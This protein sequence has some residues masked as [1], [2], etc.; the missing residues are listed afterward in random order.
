MKFIRSV[1]GECTTLHGS[2]HSYWFFFV[3]DY[4]T[5]AVSMEMVIGHVCFA[6]QSNVNVN[7]MSRHV[8]LHLVTCNTTI[9]KP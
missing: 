5:Q 1:Q 4:T 3:W 8:M 2:E 6:F 7:V 9:F